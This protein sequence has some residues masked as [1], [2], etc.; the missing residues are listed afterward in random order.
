[1]ICQYCACVIYPEDYPGKQNPV[2]ITKEG[3]LNFC[4]VFCLEDYEKDEG[5]F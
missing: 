3:I 1:M 4:S 5:I 2:I